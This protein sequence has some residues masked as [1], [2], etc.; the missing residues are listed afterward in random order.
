MS[1]YNILHGENQNAELLL[2]V[3]SLQRNTVGRYRDVFL[4]ADG[5]Q[6]LVLC[7]I[8]GRNREDYRSNWDVIRL[9]PLYERDYDDLFDSTFAW[10]RFNVPTDKLDT[11]R[12]LSTGAEPSL[13]EM[14]DTAIR[15][16]KQMT[17][18]QLQADPRFQKIRSAF[19]NAIENPDKVKIIKL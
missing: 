16:L 15:N 14:T 9:H 19:D 5:T 13:K 11:T 8:G 17:N 3:I 4:N 1:L 18:G 10:I 6:V 12:P 7:R 2:E